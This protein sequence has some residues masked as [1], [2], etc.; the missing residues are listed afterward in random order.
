M[1]RGE[2]AGWIRESLGD[3][4][5][6]RKPDFERRLELAPPKIENR[7]DRLGSE[8][9]AYGE[10]ELHASKFE[11]SGVVTLNRA[12]TGR[13]R[14]HKR[15]T[16]GT[17]E[18]LPAGRGSVTPPNHMAPRHRAWSYTRVSDAVSCLGLDSRLRGASPIC[19]LQPRRP[20]NPNDALLGLPRPTAT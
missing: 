6:R 9:G 16:G 3:L 18:S 20:A 13:K 17:R 2:L 5:V 11:D 14:H 10:S 7:L 4:I 19:R 12:A 15:R 8:C 1:I